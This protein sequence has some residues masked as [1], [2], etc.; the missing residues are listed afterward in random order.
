LLRLS[1]FASSQAFSQDNN[2]VQNYQKFD[3]LALTPPMGW[4]S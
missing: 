4:N 1:L 2:Y 3:N